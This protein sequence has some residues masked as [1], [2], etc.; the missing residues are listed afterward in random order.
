MAIDD[1]VFNNNTAGAGGAIYLLNAAAATITDTFIQGNSVTGSGGGINIATS[2]AHAILT[3]V[4]MTGNKAASN[5]GAIYENGYSDC[6]FCTISGN[7]AG[8][9]AGAIYH[10]TSV[11]ST[12]KNSI[13]YNNDA[14]DQPNYKQIYAVGSRWQYMDV[15]YTLI[16]QIPGSASYPYGYESMGG[17]LH[18]DTRTDELP[19]FVNGLEPSSAPTTSGDYHICGGLDD[20][21]GSGCGAASRC[22]DAGSP[23]YTYDHDIFGG[24]RPLGAGYDMGAH[25]KE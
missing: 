4:I 17:N 10:L 20:P 9:L 11:T 6:L 22:I 15:Y 5:G 14:L 8:N 23:S 21:P 1:S 25:E 12:I 3:S 2:T 7:Y 13:I 24:V 18:E 16:N 19:Y